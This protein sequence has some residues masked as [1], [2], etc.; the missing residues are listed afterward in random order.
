MPSAPRPSGRALGLGPVEIVE[1]EARKPGKAAEA[2]ALSPHLADAHLI[3]CDEHGQALASRDFA[4][5][6]APAAR[7]GRA[8]AR[9][10]HRR[11]R[12]AGLQRHRAPR[13]SALAFGPQTWP[14]ALVRADAG[15]AGLSGGHHP[16]RLALSSRLTRPILRRR[17]YLASLA[18][19]DSARISASPLALVAASFWPPAP[20]APRRSRRPP[21]PGR[22]RGDRAANA[23][24]PGPWADAEAGAG[25]IAQL[26]ARSST[27]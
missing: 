20:L 7:P 19:H 1:V 18:P 14:H 27:S 22:G 12:R 5:R 4:D 3:A 9:L 6:I 24:A 25:E 10:R 26:Q 21:A 2:E 17:V 11:R 16:G 23:T 13:A 8:A 15:R